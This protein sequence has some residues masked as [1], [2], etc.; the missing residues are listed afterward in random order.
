MDI[1]ILKQL[2]ERGAHAHLEK[3][4]TGEAIQARDVA[5]FKYGSAYFVR[6][7]KPTQSLECY[8]YYLNFQKDTSPDPEAVAM[9]MEMAFRLQKFNLVR[10]Y[11]FSLPP[12]VREKLS[13]QTLTIAIHSF[14]QLKQVEEA[15]KITA[16]LRN[17]SGL[18]KLP[19][20][21]GLIKE[22][23]GS[24]QKAKEFIQKN[25]DKSAAE[26][27]ATDVSQSIS[28]ALA[29]MIENNFKAAEK[30]LLAC[31]SRVAA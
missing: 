9:A 27:S 23:F 13:N 4:L 14:I 1:S 18:N 3:Y 28:L 6:R 15:D 7:G 24:A 21:E 29:Y 20:F 10:D 16:F 8:S 31:K 30:I 12:K 5:A 25:A 19:T 2:E 26:D 22:R 17:R 11:L